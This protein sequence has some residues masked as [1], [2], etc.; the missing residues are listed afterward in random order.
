MLVPGDHVP[1]L[2]GGDGPL[3]LISQRLGLMQHHSN[4]GDQNSTSNCCEGFQEGSVG[5]DQKNNSFP[6]VF[7]WAVE[8]GSERITAREDCHASP[9]HGRKGT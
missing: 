4:G 1:V 3:Q 6:S 5:P 2:Q 7:V 9:Q 8:A